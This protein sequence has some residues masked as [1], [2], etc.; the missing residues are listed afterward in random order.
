[1]INFS[2]MQSGL[3]KASIMRGKQRKAALKAE[4]AVGIPVLLYGQYVLQGCVSEGR[5]F[6]Q[7]SGLLFRDKH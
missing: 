5:D 3:Y 7:V 1:M 6:A 4:R 2:H